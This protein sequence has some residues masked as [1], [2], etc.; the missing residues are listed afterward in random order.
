MVSQIQRS[1]AKILSSP[2]DTSCAFQISHSASHL[3]G[4][5]LDIS[6]AAEEGRF[7]VLQQTTKITNW[8]GNDW[9]PR[10]EIFA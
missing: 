2:S 8:R 4:E 5:S 7:A 6:R 3:S 10:C 1:L 9:R